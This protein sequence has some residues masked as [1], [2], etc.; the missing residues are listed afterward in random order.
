MDA[1][2]ACR[3]DRAGISLVE[4]LGAIAILSAFIL[5]I[6]LFLSVGTETVR[7]TRNTAGAVFAA[8]RTFEELR[9]EPYDTAVG[10]RPRVMSLP[11]L[12]VGPVSYRRTLTVTPFFARTGLRAGLLWLKIEWARDRRRTLAYEVGTVVSDVR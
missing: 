7:G 2:P 10:D 1:R 3:G 6:I 12:A 8:N 11:D 4:V 5:P 9:N